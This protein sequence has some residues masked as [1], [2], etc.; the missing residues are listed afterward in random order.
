MLAALI[1]IRKV[2]SVAVIVANADWK[3]IA[4]RPLYLPAVN[5]NRYLRMQ[6]TMKKLGR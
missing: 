1:Y 5:A 2:F 4:Q 3:R 6:W